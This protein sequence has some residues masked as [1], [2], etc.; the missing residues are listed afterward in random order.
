MEQTGE[1]CIAVNGGLCACVCV[2]TF[3]IL[4]H[5]RTELNRYWFVKFKQ[6]T[7]AHK[8]VMCSGMMFG[9]IIS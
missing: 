6:I 7:G 8:C 9:E 1:F 3:P 2:R 5:P 4:A